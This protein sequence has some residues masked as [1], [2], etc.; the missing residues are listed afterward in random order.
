MRP[1]KDTTYCPF[2]RDCSKGNEC[3]LTLVQHM[4]MYA[5]EDGF[6]LKVFEDK[7]DCFE[8]KE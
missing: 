8:V 2:W 7:P 5:K 3:D 6:E 4:F 1:D